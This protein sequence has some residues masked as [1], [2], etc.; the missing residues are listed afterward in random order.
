MKN[1][2]KASKISKSRDASDPI[3][4]T[5]P[6]IHYKN[7]A[8]TRAFF[9]DQIGPHFRFN[10]YLRQFTK[11]E[12]ITAGLTYGDLKEGWLRAETHKKQFPNEVEIPKQFEYN[13][14]IRDFSA[15][16]KGKSLKDA[17]KAWKFTKSKPGP[18]SY[19]HYKKIL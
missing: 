3:I 16:E 14:F 4:P 9:V 18:N 5:T 13:R 7:D 1:N 17:I 8:A 2:P 10:E 19:A 15:N 12:N 6:V 11:K